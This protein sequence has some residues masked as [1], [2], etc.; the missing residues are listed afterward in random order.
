MECDQQNHAEWTSTPCSQSGAVQILHEEKL[1]NVVSFNARRCHARTSAVR[2]SPCAHTCDVGI[3]ETHEQDCEENT[4][5]RRIASLARAICNGG[6]NGGRVGG[7][8][9]GPSVGLVVGDVDG[10]E[11]GSDVGDVVGLTVGDVDSDVVGEMVGLTD[12]ASG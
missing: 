11:V 7:D 5:A 6:R 1:V 4:R 8:A 2:S 12:G 10:D 3:S 9:V